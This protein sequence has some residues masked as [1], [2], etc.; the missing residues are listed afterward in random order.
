MGWG[1]L[2]RLY[3]ASDGVFFLGAAESQRT[4]LDAVPGLAGL[5]SI[6]SDALEAALTARFATRPA[7]DWVKWLTGAGLGAHAVVAVADIVRDPWV[8]AHGLTV[9]REHRG[10]DRITTIGPPARL[11]RTPVTPGRPVSPPGGDAAEVLAEIGLAERLDDLV[12]KR[13]IALA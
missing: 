6:S 1:A 8:V 10:G 13:A 2:Q 3:A 4:A 5:G 11:S 7:A 12:A 9:T